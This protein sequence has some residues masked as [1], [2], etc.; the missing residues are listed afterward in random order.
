[1]KQIHHD[2]SQISN[3]NFEFNAVKK[4]HVLGPDQ[5]SSTDSP[6][7]LSVPIIIFLNGLWKIAYYGN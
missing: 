6:P 2:L 7:V 1:M 4:G 3:I 5:C